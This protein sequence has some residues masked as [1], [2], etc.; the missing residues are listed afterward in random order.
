MQCTV[1]LAA[2]LEWRQETGETERLLL[3]CT[4][5]VIQRV[6]NVWPWH[7]SWHTGVGCLTG[8]TDINTTRVYRNLVGRVM[9]GE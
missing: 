1:H 8:V 9:C 5:D 2:V 7:C 6:T 4:A 3:A